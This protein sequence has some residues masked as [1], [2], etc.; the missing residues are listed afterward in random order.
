MAEKSYA[1]R[2]VV[3]KLGIK[4]GMRIRILGSVPSE[5]VTRVRKVEDVELVEEADEAPADVILFEL[6]DLSDAKAALARLRKGIV[7]HGA[8]WV[9]TQKKGRPGYVRQDQLIPL[10][11]AVG[12]VDNKIAGVD[13]ETSAIRF[14][15]PLAQREKPKGPID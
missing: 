12:L 1:D 7:P 9:L 11:K 8:I 13:E 6:P 3:D 5:L 2:D 10:G 14:V 15:I 4:P